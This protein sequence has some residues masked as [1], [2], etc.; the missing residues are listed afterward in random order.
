MNREALIALLGAVKAGKWGRDTG[1]AA[2]RLKSAGIRP[3]L[4]RLFAAAFDGSLDAAKALDTAIPTR[5]VMDDA[6]AKMILFGKD[7]ARTWLLWK[8]EALI[9]EAPE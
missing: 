2:S 6:T 4:A 8:I 1:E 3:S 9:A 7:G 5:A